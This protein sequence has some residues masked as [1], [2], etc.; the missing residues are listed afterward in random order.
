MVSPFLFIL[1]INELIQTFID[2]ECD[3][4]FID[5]YYHS[6]HTIMYADDIAVF[7]DTVGRMKK[8][9][10]SLSQFCTNYGLVV[11]MAKTKIIVFRN[12]GILRRNER[13]YYEENQLEISTYYK[14]LGI[15]FS[16]SLQWSMAMRTIAQQ[17]NRAMCV[18][19]DVKYKCGQIPLSVSFELFDKMILPI[20]LYGSEVWGYEFRNIE[21]VH[22]KFCRYILGVSSRAPTCAV[23]GECG[24][25]PLYVMYIYRCVKYWIRI[26]QSLS[27]DRYPTRIYNMLFNLDS[28]GRTPWAS[29]LKHIL[30]EYGFG[31]AWFNQG[32]GNINIFL[33]E[34]KQ[35]LHDI[36]RQKW[37]SDITSS[38]KLE[39]YCQ[40]KTLLEPEKYLT[41]IA[42]D[43][44]RKALARLRCSSHKLAV[45]RLRGIIPRNERICRYCLLNEINVLEDEYH[46][47]MICPLYNELRL[48]YFPDLTLN[49]RTTFIHI[50]SSNDVI[51]TQNLSLFVYH[52]FNIYSVFL[53]I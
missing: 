14:Y 45:E 7:N 34:F 11:N 5:E 30:F 29:K 47:V 37:T 19:R 38:P 49:D 17:A 32:V 15:V 18:L 44:H 9:L 48:Q 53:G 24:R 33:S 12:G 51:I 36:S 6:V 52:A 40:F 10:D 26:V 8:Q 1:Y 2:N 16:S 28:M 3:G 39:T 31:Y 35:R 21:N 4:I 41:N 46:F 22:V 25:M 13:F 42:I 23:L 43:K 27:F 50:L 20:L